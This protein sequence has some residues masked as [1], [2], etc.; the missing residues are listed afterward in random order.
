MYDPYLICFNTFSEMFLKTI[1]MP[2][3]KITEGMTSIQNK[4]STV[5]RFIEHQ[6][7]SN[8]STHVDNKLT[9]LNGIWS[10]LP[11]KKQVIRKKIC[12]K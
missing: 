6:R 12:I 9:S 4:T 3:Q 2:C 7:R 10:L 5:E 8:S 1:Q 11:K